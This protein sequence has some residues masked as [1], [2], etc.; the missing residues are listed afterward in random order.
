M[1]GPY[2][3]VDAWLGGHELRQPPAEVPGSTGRSLLAG[4]RTA[5]AFGDAGAAPGGIAG[6][7]GLAVLAGIAAVTAV[8]FLLADTAGS[9]TGLTGLPLR[10]EAN[11]QLIGLSATAGRVYP[12][13]VA[14][15][16]VPATMRAVGGRF[17][18][19]APTGALLLSLGYTA[20]VAGALY[21]L[22]PAGAGVVPVNHQLH[23]GARRKPRPDGH[24]A[25]QVGRHPPAGEETRDEFGEPPGGMLEWGTLIICGLVL[26]LP[27]AGCD[28]GPEPDR[29]RDPG[30][31]DAVQPAHRCPAPT[32]R[33]TRALG[34]WNLTHLI[35]RFLVFAAVLLVG[36]RRGPGPGGRARLPSS[37]RARPDAGHWRSALPR[38][39][40]DLL[41]DGHPRV[42]GRPAGHSRTM[43]G[44]NAVLAPFYAAA[45]RSVSGLCLAR[46]AAGVAGHHEE[47]AAAAGACRRLPDMPRRPRGHRQRPRF[48]RPGALDPRAADGQ[49]CGRPWLC[50]G[51][52]TV[53]GFRARRQGIW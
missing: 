48:L 15:C 16:L 30:P 31:R 49:L 40:G 24:L 42:V 32:R 47:P 44:G 20:M 41:L 36:L 11:A 50:P 53:L 25:G 27:R 4:Y 6:P 21:P 26:L 14:A 33:S 52:G 3:A 18:A 29:L 9:S 19:C 51:A 35:L 23:G 13:F 28:P 46:P 34:G 45:G 37:S 39:G 17:A 43:A 7:A 1:D 38:R 10:S 22:L 5:K 12:A 8:T 2:L